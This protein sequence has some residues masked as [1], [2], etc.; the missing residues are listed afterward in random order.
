MVSDF[1]SRLSNIGAPSVHALVS[2]DP[3]CEVVNRIAVVDSTHDLGSH[4]TRRARCILRIFRAPHSGDPKVSYPEVAIR[5][6]D[7]VLGLDVSVNDILLVA[8]FQPCYETGTKELYRKLFKSE[9][10]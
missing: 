8:R 2:H 1:F 4:V 6:N 5:V 9:L 10:I 3:N 7:Q